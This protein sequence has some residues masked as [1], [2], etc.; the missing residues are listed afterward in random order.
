MAETPSTPPN[1]VGESGSQDRLTKPPAA[2]EPS[3]AADRPPA[4]SDL[5]RTERQ[6]VPHAV[7]PGDDRT[8][9]YLRGPTAYCA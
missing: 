4:A 9:T 5:K 2:P 6:V 7:E 8:E 1:P 3:P